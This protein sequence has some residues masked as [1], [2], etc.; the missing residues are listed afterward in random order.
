MRL[1][2]VRFTVRG[3]MMA[4]AAAASALGAG[5]GLHRLSVRPNPVLTESLPWADLTTLIW[6]A[7]GMASMPRRAAANIF[8]GAT[9]AATVSLGLIAW[10]CARES[11]SGML[12]AVLFIAV[13]CPYLGVGIGYAICCQRLAKDERPS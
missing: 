11:G 10:E 1:S 2:R 7:L 4:V 9:G 5:V 6:S 12:G 13:A 8:A 3:M